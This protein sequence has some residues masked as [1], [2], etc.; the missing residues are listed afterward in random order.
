M[1]GYHRFLV[2]FPLALLAASFMFDL[3]ARACTGGKSC[4][5][6][7]SSSPPK[8]RPCLHTPE[9]GNHRNDSY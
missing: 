7:G 2:H 5:A 3:W 9:D 4:T 1:A 8:R 6:T